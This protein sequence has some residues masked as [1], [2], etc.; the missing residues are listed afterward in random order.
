MMLRRD[1]LLA[2]LVVYLREVLMRRDTC[3]D[4]G[5]N[6][7]LTTTTGIYKS[8]LASVSGKHFITQNNMLLIFPTEKLM[9]SKLLNT[10][11]KEKHML[12]NS[13]AKQKIISNHTSDIYTWA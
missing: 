9:K 4:P 10:Y 6:Q 5:A 7:N 11:S 2:H 3:R 12:N 13:K 1:I 8:K